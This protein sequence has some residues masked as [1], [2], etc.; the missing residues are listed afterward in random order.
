[1]KKQKFENLLDE[2]S[3]QNESFELKSCVRRRKH[4]K[5]LPWKSHGDAY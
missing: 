4:L 5:S 2:I 3:L 1:M